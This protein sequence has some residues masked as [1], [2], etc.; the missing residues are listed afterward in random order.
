MQFCAVLLA[1]SSMVVSSYITDTVGN[2]AINEIRAREGGEEFLQKFFSDKDWMEQFAGSGTWAIASERHRL[3]DLRLSP[4]VRTQKG[5]PRMGKAWRDHD[6][7]F[8]HTKD[9]ER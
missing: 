8:P 6:A 7:V 1:A 3:S 4:A 9:R 2:D 5:L